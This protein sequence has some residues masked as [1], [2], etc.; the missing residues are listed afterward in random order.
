MIQDSLGFLLAAASRQIKKA[1]DKELKQF[2]ITAPQ[3][4][5]LAFLC[6]E[7][8]CPQT[9]I[10]EMLYW[11]KATVGDIVEKL[12]S[13]KLVTREIS[14]TDRRAYC[15]AVTDLGRALYTQIAPEV[16]IVNNL[17]CRNMSAAEQGVLKEL[18]NRAIGTLE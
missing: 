15:V 2:Q 12:L 10:A 17:A 1:F 6:E 3:W 9:Q 7:G 11:D 5:V 14:E 4:S 8:S 13:K 16:E 18:L